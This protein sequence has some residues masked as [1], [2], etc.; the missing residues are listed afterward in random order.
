[1][2]GAGPAGIEPERPPIQHVYA[3]LAEDVVRKDMIFDEVL[4]ALEAGR[5]PLVLTAR[6]DHAQHACTRWPRRTCRCPGNLPRFWKSTGPSPGTA[7][8]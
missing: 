4:S 6:K 3:A 7:P 1:M 2:T 8:G 5:S